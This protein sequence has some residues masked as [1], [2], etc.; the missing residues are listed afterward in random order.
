MVSLYKQT[1]TVWILHILLYLT[2][3]K[4]ILIFFT[5]CDLCFTL[6]FIA[7]VS[8]YILPLDIV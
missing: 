8:F 6:Y 1:L 2:I 4:Q 3:Y 7:D 5:S